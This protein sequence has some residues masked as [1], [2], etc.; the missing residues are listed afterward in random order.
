MPSF[1]QQSKRYKFGFISQSRVSFVTFP[2]PPVVAVGKVG[3]CLP[4]LSAALS[5]TPPLSRLKARLFS[6]SPYTLEDMCDL[7][8][9]ICVSS[10]VSSR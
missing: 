9:G 7:P 5:V 3:A 1:S 10:H 2:C 6:V 4:I 8:K